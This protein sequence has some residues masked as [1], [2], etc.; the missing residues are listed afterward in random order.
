MGQSGSCG[1]ITDGDRGV[2]PIAGGRSCWR[3]LRVLSAGGACD[4]DDISRRACGAPI[5][6][7]QDDNGQPRAQ[8]SGMEVAVMLPPIVSGIDPRKQ[9]SPRLRRADRGQLLG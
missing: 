4:G 1:A 6:A 3:G 9:G 7:W 2:I 8:L 5:T